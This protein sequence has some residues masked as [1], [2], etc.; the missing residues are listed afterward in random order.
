MQAKKSQE[1]SPNF[2]TFECLTCATTIS[3]RA[4]VASGG[5]G[6]DKR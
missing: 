5:A 3:E 2:D 4:P 1:D 6:G